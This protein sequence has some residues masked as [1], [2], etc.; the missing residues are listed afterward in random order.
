MNENAAPMDLHVKRF[1]QIA[2]TLSEVL[3]DNHR[4]LG[5]QS[6]QRVCEDVTVRSKSLEVLR[7]AFVELAGYGGQENGDR[8]SVALSCVG[9]EDGNRSLAVGGSP[10]LRGEVYP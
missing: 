1:Q 2:E 9:R 7:V 4:I 8:H 6:S 3:L 5:A 10:H